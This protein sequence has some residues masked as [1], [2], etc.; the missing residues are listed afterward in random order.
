MRSLRDTFETFRSLG[1]VS[2]GRE[3][4]PAMMGCGESYLSSSIARNRRPST[5]S[6]LALIANV[7]EIIKVTNEEASRCKDKKLRDDYLEGALALK[8]L[9]TETWEEIWGRVAARP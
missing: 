1:V 8:E 7:S 5:E 9:Q 2:S 3:F 6:L 4:G